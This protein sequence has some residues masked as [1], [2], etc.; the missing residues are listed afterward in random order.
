MNNGTVALRDRN[1]IK[2]LLSWIP[3]YSLEEKH[4]SCEFLRLLTACVFLLA[5]WRRGPVHLDLLSE[6]EKVGKSKAEEK[7]QTCGTLT[8]YRKLLSL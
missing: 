8:E 6:E 1:Y 7:G 3:M 4:L 5:G 2:Q